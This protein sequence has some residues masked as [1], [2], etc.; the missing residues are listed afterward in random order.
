L[1]W[2]GRDE[3]GVAVASGMYLVRLDAAGRRQTRKLLRL[4]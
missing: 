1:L 4:Q 2:D 3:R